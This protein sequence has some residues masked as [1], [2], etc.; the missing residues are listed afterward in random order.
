[1]VHVQRLL[2]SAGWAVSDV[3][4]ERVGYDLRARRHYR[5]RLIEVK[6]IWDSA[7]S[8]GIRL[9]GD[10]MIRAGIHGRDYWLYVVD[11][12]KDGRGT[13]RAVVQDPADAF[14]GL[15]RDVAVLSIKGSDLMNAPQADP[16]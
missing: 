3:S 1:M 7:A 9:T 14:D 12:C 10:E 16:T 5:Q 8:T 4:Q 6:G 15:T 13:L 11:Q 2:E